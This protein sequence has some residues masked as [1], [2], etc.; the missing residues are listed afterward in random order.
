L[1]PTREHG[2]ATKVLWSLLVVGVGSLL[3]LGTFSLLSGS[4]TNAGNSLTTG[5]V[6]VGD[7]S[8]GSAMYSDT[9]LGVGNTVDRCIQVTYTGTNGAGMNLYLPDSLDQLGQYTDLTIDEFSGSSTAF[10]DCSGLNGNSQN[11]YS[12]T[13]AD[14]QN[15]H[16]S[17]DNG[18]AVYPAPWS[19]ASAW[20]QN[21]NVVFRFTLTING[22]TPTT[23]PLTT[24]SHSWVWEA[25]G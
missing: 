10:P 19:G 18:L 25:R 22:S 21:D 20:Q 16:N 17:Y 6:S 8:S 12:G 1:G 3:L 2:T 5:S 9:G 4:T 11:M 23:G 13:L 14:F 15:N 7:N 24:G